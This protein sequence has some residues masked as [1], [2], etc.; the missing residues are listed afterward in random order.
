MKGTFIYDEKT[1]VLTLKRDDREVVGPLLI[2][3]A[4][5]R[6]VIYH[7]VRQN[8]AILWTGREGEVELI[9]ADPSILPTLKFWLGAAY[10]KL[11]NL[12]GHLWLRLNKKRRKLLKKPLW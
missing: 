4:L 9:S 1:R 12:P 8:D 6:G 10:R 7:S 5:K 2:I 3:P 11:R